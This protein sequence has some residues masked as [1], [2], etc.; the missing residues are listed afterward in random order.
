MKKQEYQNPVIKGFHPD[1]SICIVGDDAYI[2]NSTFEYFPG[3][4]I[5]HSKDMV[6]WEQIGHC[7]TDEKQLCLD[8][9]KRSSG[10]IY[11]PSIRYN[12][13]RFYMITTNIC[14]KGNFIVHT[15]DIN[16]KWSE[17][18]WIDHKGIDPSLLFDGDKVYFCGTGPDDN[19]KSA[20]ILFEINPDTGEVLS[21]KKAISYG[22]GGKYPEGPHIYHIGD[23]YYLMLA[24]GGTEYGHYET[25]QRSAS[26]WG[27][28]EKCPYNP[29][30]SNRDNMN[31][32]VQCT[33]H[34]DLAMDKNG[35]WWACCLGVRK[36]KNGLMHN[37]GRETF[38]APVTWKDAWPFVAEDGN[39]YEKMS[40]DLPSNICKNKSIDFKDDFSSKDL[41]L[42]W[43]FIRKKEKD[44]YIVKDNSLTICGSDNDLH[45]L[46]PSFVGVRQKEFCMTA[47]TTLKLK[48]LNKIGKAGITALQC[49]EHFFALEISK[50]NGQCVAS[51]QKRVM[52]MDCVR[53]SLV[54]NAEEE[55]TLR[56]ETNESEYIFSVCDAY[57]W[58]EIGKGKTV[59]LCTE[60]TS[61][62]TF[63]GVFI[64]LFAVD[65][66][67]TFKKFSLVT[68]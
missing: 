54:L 19:K 42:N 65:T 15:D 60:T 38:V 27:P 66:N 8:N 43:T 22:T 28:Y 34:A 63:T 4:P 5:F 35:N 36:L 16:G 56:I 17:P 30:I 20:I 53:Q 39:I 1:P 45:D 37:L 40:A 14:D 12:N 18:F 41:D 55:I 52:D 9:C 64:A 68:A 31:S 33:G 44:R 24:E 47:E 11:A 13:G 58:H 3:V 50:Q 21:E 7:L 46:F 59:A 62:N 29:I 6:D 51:L 26:V 48:D 57:G 2:V 49:K 10:G 32:R 23:Y 61:P 67:A 25:I